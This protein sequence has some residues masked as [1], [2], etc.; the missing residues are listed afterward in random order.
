MRE[1]GE[2]IG[3]VLEFPDLQRISGYR[4]LADVQKWADRIGL[5]VTPCRAGLTSTVDAYNKALGV[6]PDNGHDAAYLP[7]AA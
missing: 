6:S 3:P 7:F 5:S 2:V 1:G 4:R